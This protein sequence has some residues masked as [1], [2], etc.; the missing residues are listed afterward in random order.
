MKWA[1]WILKTHGLTQG[2]RSIDSRRPDGIDLIESL[3]RSGWDY[4][5]ASM[6]HGRLM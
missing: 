3:H 1:I 2:V 6:R 4:M 5:R